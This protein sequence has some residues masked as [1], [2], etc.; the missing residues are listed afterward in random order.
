MY[1][2]EFHQFYC[3]DLSSDDYYGCCLVDFWNLSNLFVLGQVTARI[4]VVN[5]L[6]RPT[7]SSTPPALPARLK[8]ASSSGDAFRFGFEIEGMAPIKIMAEERKLKIPTSIV[9]LSIV[10]QPQHDCKI[11]MVTADPTPPP[12]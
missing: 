6:V 9:P 2:V 11:A 12:K 7:G 8:K 10:M 3:I 5:S 1:T 4:W